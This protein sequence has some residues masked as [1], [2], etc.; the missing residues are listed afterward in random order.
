MASAAVLLAAV[1]FRGAGLWHGLEQGIVF[2][3]D[4]PKQVM[5]LESYLHGH[6]VHHIGNLFYYVMLTVSVSL[7]QWG[8]SFLEA[9]WAKDLISRHCAFTTAFFSRLVAFLTK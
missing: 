3:P 4:E 9:Y 1:G 6:Y 8:T 2:H 5:R 7:P